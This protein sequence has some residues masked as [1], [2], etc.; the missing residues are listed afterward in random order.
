MKHSCPGLKKYK[1]AN[2]NKPPHIFDSKL[3]DAPDGDGMILMV[4]Y[5][6]TRDDT[7]LGWGMRFNYCPACGEDLMY[8]ENPYPIGHDEFGEVRVHGE[9]SGK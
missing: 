1:M 6:N 8:S 7:K 9:K 4:L 5:M 2:F 3:Q